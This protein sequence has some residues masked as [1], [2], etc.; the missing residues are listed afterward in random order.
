MDRGRLLRRAAAAV[1]LGA[2]LSCARAGAPRPGQPLL[3]HEAPDL[4]VRCFPVNVDTPAQP[5]YEN[6][7]LAYDPRTSD[8]LI[9]DPG[10]RSGAMER[11]VQSHAL[12]VCAI[13]NTHGHEDHIGADGYYAGRYGAPVSAHVADA[14]LFEGKPCTV[15]FFEQEGLLESPCAAFEIRVLLTPGHS[16]GSVGYLVRGVL[17]SGDTLFAGGIGRTWGDTAEEKRRLTEEEKTNIREKLFLLPDSTPVYPGHDEATTIGAEKRGN[18][19][20]RA[21]AP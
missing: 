1:L 6:L 21:E 20:F 19:H 4:V 18:P 5:F 15:A 11:F 13:L 7:Y 8:A 17:F 12:R 9:V 2:A 14:P 10:A 3:L 16:P